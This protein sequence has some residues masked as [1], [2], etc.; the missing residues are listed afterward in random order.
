MTFNRDISFQQVRHFIYFSFMSYI[1]NDDD[2]LKKVE[3]CRFIKILNTELCNL[4]LPL[5]RPRRRW[6]DNIKMDLQEVGGSYGEWM[7]LAQDRDRWRA[8]V[9]A[10]MNFRVPENA[11]NFLTSC[12]TS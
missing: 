4:Y 10:V 11:E 2:R 7:E 3:I 1:T 9:S 6:E 5:G 12:R 8:V